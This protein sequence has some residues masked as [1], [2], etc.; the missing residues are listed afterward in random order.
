M[1]WLFPVALV[2]VFSACSSATTSP[3]GPESVVL[4]PDVPDPGLD[5]DPF[6]ALDEPY[7]S[8]ADPEEF[9]ATPVDPPVEEESYLSQP[10]P[11]GPPPLPEPEAQPGRAQMPPQDQ[12]VAEKSEAM[13]PVVASP[14]ASDRSVRQ[15]FK[16]Y[17][18]RVRTR[19]QAESALDRR[20]LFPHEDGAFQLGVDYAHDAFSSYDFDPGPGEVRPDSMGVVLSLSY[21][22]LRGLNTGRLG[23]GAQGGMYWSEFEFTTGGVTDRTRRH[24]INTYG[25]RLTYEF[26]YF[27]GQLFVPFAFYGME[28]VRVRNF[29]MTHHG[30]SLPANQFSSQ[31][32]GAGAHLNLNRLEPTTAS[33]ALASSGIRKF[34]LSYTLQQRT[35]SIG[36]S[37]FL[38]LR[39]EY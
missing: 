15:D 5:M 18:D 8:P 6:L 39:F 13:P 21:F 35:E 1:R 2:L 27:L 20:A 11:P 30:V 32:Y 38:G 14:G 33:K 17:K 36:A 4:A 19:Q 37:H 24:S 31:I 9:L 12:P 29:T 3:S 28:G 7:S 10:T 26:Q 22:P 23:I 16:E 25:A 34:Y